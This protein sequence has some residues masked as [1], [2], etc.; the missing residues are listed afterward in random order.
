MAETIISIPHEKEY[1]FLHNLNFLPMSSQ[2]SRLLVLIAFRNQ[3]G[4]CRHSNAQMGEFLGCTRSRIVAHLKRLVDDGFI[5]IINPGSRKT[6]AIQITEKTERIIKANTQSIIDEARKQASKKLGK[7]AKP[8]SKRLENKP[9]KRLEN[10]PQNPPQEARKQA[11]EEEL[12]SNKNYEEILEPD[13]PVGLQPPSKSGLINSIGVDELRELLKTPRGIQSVAVGGF[14][15][16]QI[17][18]EAEVF[19]EVYKREQYSTKAKLQY[20]FIDHLH[21]LESES[22][23]EF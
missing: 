22:P 16:E 18:A 12:L 20:A 13:F 23:R 1:V 19:M 21:S 2:D 8:E 7:L 17:L 5:E 9:S 15:P 4:T 14:S 3:V 10:K 11:T 6:R